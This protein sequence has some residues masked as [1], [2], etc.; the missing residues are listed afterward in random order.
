MLILSMNSKRQRRPN[1]RL[2]EVGD[3]PAAFACGFSQKGKGD[4]GGK[5]WKHD[6]VVNPDENELSTI[7]GFSNQETPDFL[8]SE[9]GV[10]PKVSVDLQQNREN[11]NPNSAKSASEFASSDEI[12]GN[13]TE[14]NFGTITRRSRVMRRR[15]Q[16]REGKGNDFVPGNA[17]TWHSKVI[18]LFSNE[19]KREGGEKEYI[20][21]TSSDYPGYNSGDG[22]KEFSD[23]ETPATSK[24]ACDYDTDEPAYD[25][26]QQGNSNQYWKADACRE[27]SHTFLRS[28]DGWYQ[29]RYGSNDINNVRRWLEEV[30]F[31]KY[32]D[33]FEM[34]EVDEQTLPHL[35]L[36]DL[37]E[38][39]V[40]AVGHRRKLY[41][42]IQQLGG[43]DVSA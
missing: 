14:L 16:S 30:G 26:W 25:M 36:E 11:K 43:R 10:A 1:V 39:G 28:G 33:V 41:N 35:T 37:K 40:F 29:M 42:A 31:G 2:G 5:R 9:F 21:I 22:F 3:I 24:E 17:W 18:P 34:H 23:H 4:F 15:G 12:D 8:D 6:F 38:M 27:G 32:A 19:D 20:G 13:K 7:T